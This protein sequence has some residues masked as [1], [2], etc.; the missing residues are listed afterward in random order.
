MRLWQDDSVG[1]TIDLVHRDEPLTDRL[2]ERVKGLVDAGVVERSGR[3][4]VIL[5]RKFYAF[6]GEK[7]VHTRKKGLDRE[8]E[9]ELLL[10]HITSAGK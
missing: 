5:S 7:G 1:L 9:K 6:L 8:T 10:R 2:R 4:K 3:G